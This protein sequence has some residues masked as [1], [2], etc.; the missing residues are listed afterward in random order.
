M[1]DLNRSARTMAVLTV[2]SRLSGFARV[3]VFATVFGK[4]Y[5]A[6]TYVSSNTLPNI[7]FELFAA[8]ALQADIMVQ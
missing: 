1:T 6:N 4:T 2:V 7:L 8:G 3:V 5:L